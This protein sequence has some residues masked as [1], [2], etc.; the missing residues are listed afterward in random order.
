MTPKAGIYPGIP[1][2]EYKSWQGINSTFLHTL[3]TRSPYHAKHDR[4][5]PK[6]ETDALRIG[7]ALHSLILEP[8]T[9]DQFWYVLP[10]DCPRRPSDRQRNAKSPSAETIK[11][12]EF[13]DEVNGSGKSIVTA[14]EFAEIEADATE[15]RKQQCMSLVCAGRA[16]VSIVWEDEKT[17]LLCKRR[18]DYERQ[19]SERDWNHYITDV[20]SSADISESAFRRDIANYGY[21][22]AAAFSI[23]GWKAL[24]GDGSIY[25]LLAIEKVYHVAKVW[26]PGEMT[27]AAGRDDYRKAL[28][29]AAQCIKTGEWEA[30]GTDAELIEAPDWYL[31]QHG[32]SQYSMI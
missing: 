10:E 8:A 11:A 29:T 17:G 4:D 13:W 28:D 25:N 31:H 21:A 19:G 23:D 26:E 30:Y 3:A 12:I 5:N 32:L 1:F 6:E 14:K 7:R 16:E 27:I 20:K 24:T 22:M 18:L 2:A 9:F 15:V